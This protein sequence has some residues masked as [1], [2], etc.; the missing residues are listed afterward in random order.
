MVMSD[1]DTLNAS[2]FKAK[3]LDLLDQVND[4]RIGRL[5]VTK[6]GRP[7]AVVTA[8]PVSE[9]AVRRFLAEMRGSVIVPEG[10]D[11][12][13]PALDEPMDAELGIL[14]R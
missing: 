1:I 13:E 14:H 10:V 12:T 11:L 9:D 4:G 7:V 6:R 3:C 8:P 5:V 2:E